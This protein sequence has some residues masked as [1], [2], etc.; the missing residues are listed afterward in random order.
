MTIITPK[1]LIDATLLLMC[2]ILTH[3][4]AIQHLKS[5]LPEVVRSFSDLSS[6][7]EGG[8][9]VAIEVLHMLLTYLMQHTEEETGVS[10]DTIDAFVQ[11]LRRGSVALWC[12]GLCYRPN[13]GRLSPGT[14][15]SGADAPD[16]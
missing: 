13:P 10:K 7:L 9:D 5:K 1:H 16:L 2:D 3:T 14:G 6:G 4:S 12:S 11:S 8:G 15:A